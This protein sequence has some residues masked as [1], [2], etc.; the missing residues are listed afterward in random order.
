MTRE[1]AILKAK[2]TRRE[3]R[4]E[5]LTAENEEARKALQDAVRLVK[6]LQQ[7]NAA[8]R[9]NAEVLTP[10]RRI[11]KQLEKLKHAETAL[12]VTKAAATYLFN[13]VQT[14]EYYARH[15]LPYEVLVPAYNYEKKA[16]Q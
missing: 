3:K 8:L 13:A 6:Q 10:D 16:E 12:E 9:K 15:K 4:I 7:T 5:K 14:Y 11:A 2:L 1:T